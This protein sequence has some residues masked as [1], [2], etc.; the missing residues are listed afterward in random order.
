[1]RLLLHLLFILSLGSCT[2]Y[3]YITMDSTE[4]PLGRTKAFLWETDTISVSYNFSGEGGQM[5][6]TVFNKSN[7][8]L[9]IN[10]KKSAVIRDG[11]I[12]SLFNRNVMANGVIATDSYHAG[13]GQTAGYSRFSVSFDVPEGIEFV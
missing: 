5:I 6:V 8:P 13:A 7:Q 11:M 1:M 2:S 4:I 9:F 10:W 3:N 12:V